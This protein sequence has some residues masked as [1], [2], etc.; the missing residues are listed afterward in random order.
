MQISDHQKITLICSKSCA[1]VF[2]KC[3]SLI[4]RFENRQFHPKKWNISVFFI[5]TESRSQNLA[6]FELAIKHLA[7]DLRDFRNLAENGSTVLNFVSLGALVN[8]STLCG[9]SYLK[10]MFAIDI[11]YVRVGQIS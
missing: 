11:L 7:R 3:L 2:R 1:H 5:G 10:I 9:F 6:R 8:F 4:L